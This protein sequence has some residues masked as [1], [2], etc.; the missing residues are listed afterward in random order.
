MVK[1][2]ENKFVT[3]NMILVDVITKYPEV[4][5]ILMGYGLHCV[6]CHFSSID[7]IEN[8]AKLHGL[9][10]EMIEMMLRDANLI[11]EKFNAAKSPKSLNKAGL[12]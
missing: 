5:P 3:K 12:T 8:G 2:T 9:D 1:K 7:T 6:G 11:I 4:A 10:D